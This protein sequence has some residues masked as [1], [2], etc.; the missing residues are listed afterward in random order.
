MAPELKVTIPELLRM[1]RSR[2][3]I[4]MLTAYDYSMARAIDQAGIE[5]ILVGDSLG[6]VVLGYDSTTAVT[7]EEMLHHAR[8]VRRGVTRSLVIGDMPF[9]SFHV[10]LRDTVKNA[11]RFLQDAGCD[12]VKIEWKPGIEDV[13]K[14]IVD[15][16]IPVM[17]HVGLTPQ[18]AA[19]QG[20]F[21]VQGRDAESAL[22]IHT[23]AVALQEMGC[24]AVVLECVPDVLAKEITERLTIPT[25]G[26]GA[27]PHCDGQVLV[28]Y[29]L[30]G[31][32]EAFTP[33]FVRRY[34]SMAETIRESVTAFRDD[35]RQGFFPGREQTFTMPPEEMSRL[36][37]EL[38]PA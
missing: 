28:S 13:A 23:Q 16:G 1:K 6:M 34:A 8:A 19:G 27:G 17:G 38:G 35:V 11:G 37:Q 31:L 14:A 33:K 10:S 29:D 30:L 4:T 24:F 7:M 25:I 15:A 21:R 20:G 36:Q 3:K 9:L 22:R 18:T 5:L 32:Y 2:S 12:A 26:I